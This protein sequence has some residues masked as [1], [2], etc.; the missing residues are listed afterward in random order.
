[1]HL[2]ASL[3]SADDRRSVPAG[4]TSTDAVGGCSRSGRANFN[5]LPPAARNR[6]GGILVSKVKDSGG[7][8]EWLGSGL[9][10]R[11]QRFESATR[12]FV[13]RILVCHGL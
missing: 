8:A 12:L 6:S 2:V 13:G 1:M 4:L 3:P 9:Q 11:V 5:E 7:L 10:S